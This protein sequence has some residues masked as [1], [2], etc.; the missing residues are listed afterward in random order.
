MDDSTHYVTYQHNGE[1]VHFGNSYL[2][3]SRNYSP[4]FY[5][6]VAE[7]V[8]WRLGHPIPRDADTASRTYVRGL[9]EWASTFVYR[10][11]ENRALYDA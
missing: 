9:G 8:E 6:R 10:L 4:A 7:T 3:C 11:A 2:S 1:A 5:A